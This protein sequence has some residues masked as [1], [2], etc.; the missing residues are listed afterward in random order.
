M[1]SFSRRRAL[2]STAGAA[3]GAG[4]LPGPAAAARE[5]AAA[6]PGPVSV[7]PDDARYADLISGLNQRWVAAPERIVLPTT[8]RQVVELV[9]DAVNRDKRISIQGGGHCFEDFVFN[10]EVEVVINMSRMNR[11]HFDPERQAFAVEGGATLLNVYETLYEGW[12]V[13]IPGGACYSVGVG[14]H[15]SGGGYGMLS[16]THGLTVDHLDAVEVV[17]VDA[18]GRARSVVAGRD[19]DDPNHDLFWAHT[20]AG[21]GNFGVITKYWFRTPGTTGS[22]PG[23]LLPT[24]PAE[25]FVTMVSWPWED[26]SKAGFTA[27]LEFY[28]SWLE[29]HKDVTSPYRDMCVWLMPNH[30][31]TGDIAL[32]A[33]LDATLPDAPRL[34]TDF[35]AG[36]NRA[37]G[38]SDTPGVPE[39]TGATHRSTY[40]T[41]QRLPWLRATRYVGTS[42]PTQTDPNMRGKHKSAYHR[43]G[44]TR[45]QIETIYEHLTRSPQ[46]ARI[47]GLVIPSTGGRIAEVDPAATAVAQRDSI[48]KVTYETYW[49][50]ESDDAANIAWVRGVY[51]DVYAATGGVPVPGERTDGCYVNYPDSDIG[52][53]RYNRSSVPWHD[54]YFKGN[55]RRLQEVKRRW[56]PNDVFRHRQ[57]VRA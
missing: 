21:G 54:L 40:A 39:A 48:M 3:A 18:S 6:G 37:L 12:G 13:T 7:K 47:A 26:V 19:P 50:D 8:T 23:A 20:G 4:L 10:S 42:S 46:S 2:L 11:I 27:L 1:S 5:A 31:S 56:D 55:Y 17:V 32:I 14:G 35:L 36:L 24:P 33:Q 38:V 49:Y 45:Q 34:L 53:P 9:Q 25:V 51:G 52:D 15:V 43:R 41:T 29:R 22:A 28:G 30:Q 44:F 57:S 16:R